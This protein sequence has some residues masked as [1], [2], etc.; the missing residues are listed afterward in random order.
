VIRNVTCT[1]ALRILSLT[2]AFLVLLSRAAGAQRTEDPKVQYPELAAVLLK[3]NYPEDLRLLGI[4]GTVKLNIRVRPGPPGTADSVTVLAGSGVPAL[5]EAAT[6]TARSL[7]FTRPAEPKWIELELT[8]TP[9][10]SA[11]LS[12]SALPQLLNRETAGD[13]AWAAV[14]ERTRKAR[15]RARV[16]VEVLVDSA[17][18]PQTTHATR[19]GCIRDFDQAALRGAATLQFARAEPAN[20]AAARRTV[21][22][23]EFGTDSVAVRT[24][25]EA[26]IPQRAGTP[27]PV[28]PT[29]KPFSTPPRLRNAAEISSALQ[30]FYPPRLRDRGTG[31]TVGLWLFIDERGNVL[32]RDIRKS[33]GICELDLAA[34]DVAERMRFE[35]AR[36]NGAPIKVWIDIPVV[37]KTRK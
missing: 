31:G 29:A 36:L 7:L 10:L 21:V 4:G 12:Y 13:S 19:S 9:E 17:G 16:A 26:R 23:F 14:P 11:R 22:T 37:F 20:T 8:F 30:R 34:L 35:P 3:Q 24:A 28:P 25:G 18:R 6:L 1:G 15:V 27:P 2:M 32:S 5:D 33:S